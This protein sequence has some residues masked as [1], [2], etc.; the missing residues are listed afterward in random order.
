MVLYAWLLC[1]VNY[2]SI[3]SSML[4]LIR[5]IRLTYWYRIPSTTASYHSKSKSGSYLGMLKVQ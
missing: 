4:Y 3:D 1:N 5:I 2:E